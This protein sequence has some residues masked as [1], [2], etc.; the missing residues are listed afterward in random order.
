MGFSFPLT[1]LPIRFLFQSALRKNNDVKVYVINPD[2]SDDLKSR[3]KQI[4][5]EEQLQWDFCGINN[6]LEK[7][8]NN[9]ILNSL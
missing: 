8:I 6:S 4:F 7:F 2:S 3:Y 1:D 5:A 9:K